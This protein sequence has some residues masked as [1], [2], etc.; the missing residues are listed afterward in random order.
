MAPVPYTNPYAPRGMDPSTMALLMY[1]M[2]M[3]QQQPQPQKPGL[4]GMAKDLFSKGAEGSVLNDLFG[5]GG[6]AALG[7]AVATDITS[8]MAVNPSIA[9]PNVLGAS[10]VPAADP[11][12]FGNFSS[13]GI[14][15]QAGIT[16]GIAF[17][18]KGIKDLLNNKKTKGLKTISSRQPFIKEQLL[19]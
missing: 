18:A 10:R 2:K 16:A 4:G 1:L 9:T 6:S 17:G 14:G 7:D 12:I 8:G 15:P 13:M 5:G 3:K 19:L 11:T